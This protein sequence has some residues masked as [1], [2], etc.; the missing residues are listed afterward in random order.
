MDTSEID[1]KFADAAQLG[2]RLLEK[3][4]ALRERSPLF[5]SDYQRAWI[6]TGHALVTA[7]LRGTVPLSADRIPRVLSF[8]P[9]AE[10]AT[11]APY[12]IA[13]L[14][15]MVISLDPPEHLR[16]RKLL[17][18]AFSHGVVETYRPYVKRIIEELLCAN[19]GGEQLEFVESIARQIPART[20]LRLMGLGETLLPRMQ[21]W[22]LAIQSGFGAGGTTPQMLDETEKVLY[23]MRSAF[24]PEIEDRRANPREDFISSLLSPAE[25]GMRLSDEEI[26]ATCYL[27]LIAGHDT[28]SNTIVLGTVALAGDPTAWD[29]FRQTTDPARLVDG[30]MELSRRIAMTTTMGRVVIKDF[31]WQGRRLNKG[32]IVYLMIGSANR[33]PAAFPDPTRLDFS[34]PQT[35]NMS[36]GP[37]IHFCIG[38]L[39]AKLQLTEFSPA[40]TRRFAGMEILDQTL[41]WGTTVNFRGLRSL[42]VRLKRR[43]ASPPPSSGAM[44]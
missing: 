7:A 44:D 41:Q 27:V 28:T 30:V 29:Y 39:L 24:M 34:R 12:A 16:L 5:W 36:F 11:R 10:R 1:V 20:I 4:D 15:R 8:L 31:E 37:G 33:D 13:S 42:N 18:R 3:L 32:D 26:L 23:E 40:L 19:E 38:P 17:A 21:H 9:E 14:R 25:D 6:V 35:N 43:I 22:A 2:N